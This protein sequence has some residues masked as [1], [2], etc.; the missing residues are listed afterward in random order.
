MDGEPGEGTGE[1]FGDEWR[2][3]VISIMSWPMSFSSSSGK[4]RSK[5]RSSEVGGRDG[6]MMLHSNW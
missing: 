4:G 6:Y 3:P 1:V 2:F 5:G